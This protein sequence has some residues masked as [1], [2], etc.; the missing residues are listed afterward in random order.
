M[1]LNA[2]LVPREICGNQQTAFAPDLTSTKENKPNDEDLVTTRQEDPAQRP[3]V[4]SLA[5][6]GQDD[7]QNMP[8]HE[9]EKVASRCKSS[10]M[11]I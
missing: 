8:H 6:D 9:L 2:G 1:Y 11:P 3:V 4:D 10:R 5:E 7:T